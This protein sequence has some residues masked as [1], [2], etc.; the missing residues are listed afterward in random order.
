MKNTNERKEERT[1]CGWH[2]A[3]LLRSPS[4]WRVHRGQLSAAKDLD[5]WRQPAVLCQPGADVVRIGVEQRLGGGPARHLSAG[6][7][8]IPS[9]MEAQ[10][11]PGG[12]ANAVARK[13]AEQH[14]ARR[15]T[16]SI[17]DHPLAALPHVR[18]AR[19]VLGHEATPIVADADSRVSRPD[20][21]RRDGGAHHNRDC[22]RTG[23]PNANA[24]R[25]G[26]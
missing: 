18:K 15:I 16:R 5:L 11:R 8:A 19:G 10:H 26:P 24:Q 25:L 22:S 23:R 1:L 4:A 20:A 12:D 14:G 9:R 17:D 6:R 2:G 21:E 13:H 3:K 7:I